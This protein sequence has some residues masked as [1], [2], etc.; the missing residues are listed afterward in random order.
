MTRVSIVLFAL[1]ILIL[2]GCS[3]S[4]S[5]TNPTAAT[6]HVTAKIDGADFSTSG[7]TAVGFMTSG[8]LTVTGNITTGGS[9]RQI[10]FVLDD[11]ASG[12][13]YNMAT[14]TDES[15]VVLMMGTTPSDSYLAGQGFGS[16]TITITSMS[17]SEVSGTFSFV[18][19]NGVSTKTVTGGSFKVKYSVI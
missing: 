4:D 7:G 5:T 15:G 17:G 16:G 14:N 12:K 9:T 6:Y 3:S 11:A 2:S 19:S 10:S 8:T 1:G 13:S 18:A